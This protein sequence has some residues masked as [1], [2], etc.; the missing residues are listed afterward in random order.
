MREIINID[1]NAIIVESK[2]LATSIYADTLTKPQL[3]IV[4]CLISL[5]NKNDDG[6]ET[7]VIPANEILKILR[8]ANPRTEEAKLL[9]RNTIIGLRKASFVL[10]NEDEL[11]TFGWIDFAKYDKKMNTLT[12]RLSDEVKDLYIGLKETGLIYQLKNMLVLSTVFQ[13][14]LY[15]WA[16]SKKNFNNDVPISIEDIKEL[17]NKKDVRTADFISKYLN[18][19][20]KKINEKTDLYLEYEKIKADKEN[21]KRITSLKF[22]ISSN[23]ERNTKKR[24][25]SKIKADNKKK[26]KLWQENLDLQQKCEILENSNSILKEDNHN[27]NNKI[28]ML[29][30]NNILAEENRRLELINEELEIENFKLKKMIV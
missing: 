29:Q 18:P 22:K 2:K 26:K 23:Y 5:I 20:I 12:I 4:M 8:P 15:E 28:I 3:D 16:Y 10:E 25:E 7:Y 27:K 19:A 17:F 30:N 11:I 13:A 6:F 14:K 21:K 9:L 1:K 24:T